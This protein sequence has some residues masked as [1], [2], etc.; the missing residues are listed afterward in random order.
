M[1]TSEKK[2]SNPHAGHRER[3]RKRFLEQGGE[4]F[5]KHELLELLLYNAI[6]MQDTNPIAHRLMDNFDNS[7]NMLLNGDCRDI[8]AKCNVS[9]NTAIFLS[10]IGE[11]VKRCQKERTEGRALINS[12][13]ASGRYA[14]N[15]MMYETI[16]KFYMLCLDAGNH[17]IQAI[18]ISHGS[19]SR[20]QVEAG[21]IV[22]EALL[23][24]AV[25]VIFAHNHPGGNLHPSKADINLTI[26]LMSA[27]K[28][29]GIK[30]IDH[31][32]TS[33]ENYFSFAD[34]GFIK[35]DTCY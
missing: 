27:L 13:E 29:V 35:N 11:I 32:I 8:V 17:L 33:G 4:S 15:L 12:T 6:P 24:K 7:F 16:E 25:S 20:V 31:I 9:I 28:T 14:A 1:S 23:S 5:E 30:V 26:A 22:K 21:D 34:N 10:S 3:V 18:C 19:Q 2:K